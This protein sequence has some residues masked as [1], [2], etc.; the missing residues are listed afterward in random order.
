MSFDLYVQVFVDGS[1]GGFPPQ[2]LREAV[3]E[4]LVELE[5]DFWQVR[6]SDAE[7]SDFFLQP[8]AHDASLIHTL[9]I[10][11]PCNDPRLWRALYALLE[12]P[13]TLFHFPGCTAPLTRDANIAAAAPRALLAALGAPLRIDSPA[14]LRQAIENLQEG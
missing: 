10:H 13:G 6:Y 1:E 3:G 7:S 12:F 8:C 2:L 9:S 5:D 4:P 14:Q 11:R